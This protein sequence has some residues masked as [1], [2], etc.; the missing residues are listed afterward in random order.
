MDICCGIVIL[1]HMVSRPVLQERCTG[2]TIG[3]DLQKKK[4]DGR[5]GRYHINFFLTSGMAAMKFFFIRLRLIL[6]IS[7]FFLLPNVQGFCETV[8]I[9][10]Q[11]DYPLLNSMVAYMAFSGPEKSVVLVDPADPCRKIILSDPRFGKEK[12]MVRFETRVHMVGGTAMGT[13]CVLPIEWDGFLVLLEH[14]EIDPATWELRF[15]KIDSRL[16]DKNRKPALLINELWGVFEGGVLD[17]I[18][19]IRIPL[20]PPVQNL[21]GLLLP[22]VPAPNITR[23]EKFFNSMHPGAISVAPSGL[24]L[25]ILARFEA[26]SVLSKAPVPAPLTP[27]EL[28]DFIDIWQTYD[29]FLVQTLLSLSGKSLTEEDR[30]LLLEVL[31]DTRYRFVD[32]LSRPVTISDRDFVREQFVRAWKRLSPILRRHIGGQPSENL[33]RYLSFFTAS[34]ALAA[35]DRLGPAFN[36]EISADGLI[37][38]VRMLSQ[39]KSLLLAYSTKV[40]PALR[41]LLG[42]G[43][44]IATMGPD[45]DGL[46]L[47]I[48]SPSPASRRTGR[49]S[50]IWLAAA[51]SPDVCHASGVPSSDVARAVRQWLVTE[52]NLDAY[53]EKI[54]GMLDTA[55]QK[56]MT[57]EDFSPDYQSVFR[58][59]VL[60]TAWQES[61][62]RQFIE[63]RGKVTCLRS[64]NNSSVGMMQVNERVW[65]GLFDLNHLRWD[66]RY[67]VAAGTQIIDNYFT[68]YAIPGMKKR[69]T[70]QSVDKDTLACAVYAMYNS[71][72]G[73]FSRYLKRRRSG[74]LL[75]IDKLFAQK[76]MWVK[77]NQFDKL[78]IC[79]FGK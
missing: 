25:E 18:G 72:P 64:Y 69:N 53:A 57:E 5:I 14:P 45:Y 55:A 41:T 26:P 50:L 15:S 65:R 48:G 63:N 42:M 9:P 33:L 13:R 61:C 16:L 10:M 76:Y 38:L 3:F 28:A 11:V 79:L 2:F 67:N 71:G 78:R 52:D 58:R 1:N 32:A 74:R 70:S 40:D 19:K 66:I 30:N 77:E 31:L 47:D 7:G 49:S 75:K 4:R 27:R 29:A 34:D 56:Q 54:R 36:I 44:P 51:I 37:R 23:M 20:G 6:F 62:F 46:E 68:R 39:N 17:F 73:A 24:R 8:S 60:A 43:P 59:I 22:M 12:G 35:F 21:K